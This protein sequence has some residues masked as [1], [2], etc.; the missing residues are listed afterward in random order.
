MSVSSRFPPT[1]FTWDTAPHYPR[2]QG[3]GRSLPYIFDAEFSDGGFG[4]FGGG[5]QAARVMDA[6]FKKKH[7]NS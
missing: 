5:C 1:D 7:S 4:A 2:S 6:F 3:T